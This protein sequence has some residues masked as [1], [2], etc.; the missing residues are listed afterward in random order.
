MSTIAKESSYVTM[1]NVFNV[2]PE[3]QQELVARLTDLSKN[4]ICYF[5]GFVSGNI[6]RS[7]D[8]TQVVIYAQWQTPAHFKNFV[9]KKDFIP[10]LEQAVLL[11]NSVDAKVYEVVEVYDIDRIN[12]S[13]GRV[14]AGRGTARN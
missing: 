4:T 9:N 11:A 13:A 12:A 7:L 14:D 8:G 1:I 10:Q 3:N 6:H 2:D 5:P